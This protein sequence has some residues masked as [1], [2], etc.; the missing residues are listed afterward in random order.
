M[1][2]CLIG[3]GSNEGDR[4]ANLLRA[5]DEL[6][7]QCGVRVLRRS[8]FLETVPAG[9]PS[10]QGPYLN[11]AAVLESALAPE[12]LLGVLLRVEAALGR[13]RDE[14]WGPRVIDLDLLLY[15]ELVL[16]TPTL[17]VPHPRMAW[18]RFVLEPAADI[19]G[20]MIHPPTGWNIAR[21]LEHLN[22][23]KNYVAITGPIGSG[24]T[25]LA[26]QIAQSAGAC[27]IAESLDL[28]RLGAFYADPAGHA[29]SAEIEF[30]NRRSRLLAVNSPEWTKPAQW[31]VSDF[32][33]DQSLA[34]ADVWLPAER[35]AAFRTLW[36]E[37]VRGV[38]RPKLI[39]V[40]NAATERIRERID[41]RGRLGESRLTG[42]VLER[43]REALGTCL[44]R[45]DVGPVL[46][47]TDE[48]PDQALR[49][50]VA[51]VEA[52]K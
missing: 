14:R 1:S 6:G 38:V 9:G 49:Q 41:E 22:T 2:L 28:A 19:A 8:R 27:W 39:V 16:S 18:R 17:A 5:L 32:W 42:D 12:V 10:G 46:R 31:W 20:S 26:R 37:A 45:P 4:E 44:R 29:W 52:M 25:Q 35:R 30:L 3:L 21:L 51:A 48:P 50:V 34:F 43:V 13:R 24:K 36:E 33:F 15:D 11:A 40:N 7:Q 47:L 23:A